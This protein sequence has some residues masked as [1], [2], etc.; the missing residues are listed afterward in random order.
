MSMSTAKMY[1]TR[2]SGG[3]VNGM[4]DNIARFLIERRLIMKE[5]PDRNRYVQ[6]DSRSREPHTDRTE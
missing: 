3:Y 5:L 2:R 4:L 6:P 1:S